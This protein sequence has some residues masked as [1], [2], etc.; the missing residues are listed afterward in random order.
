MN[1]IKKHTKRIATD[2][3]GYL[4][5]LLG[6]A[7]GW[8]PG[9]GGIPLVLAGLGLLSINNEWAARLRHYLAKNSERLIKIAFPDHKIIQLVY[10]VV[11]TVLL[12]VGIA[13]LIR[14]VA[15]W[16]ISLGVTL[17]F[18]ALTLGLVNR[19]RYLVFKRKQL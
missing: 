5:I 4:L 7:L 10:D 14:H 16:Q 17:L 3:A 8:L 2:F 11:A 1:R 9:P 6:A 15:L 13:Y 12:I 19:E 18:I